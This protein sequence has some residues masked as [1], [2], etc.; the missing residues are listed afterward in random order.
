M[1]RFGTEPALPMR[2][3]TPIEQ[4]ISSVIIRGEDFAHLL[5]VT[6]LRIQV[7]MLEPSNIVNE[8]IDVSGMAAAH[9]F[10]ISSSRCQAKEPQ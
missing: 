6:R 5:K 7:Y 2:V 4:A 8:D 10:T 9:Q 3:A 1:L